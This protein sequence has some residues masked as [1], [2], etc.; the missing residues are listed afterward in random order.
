[1]NRNQQS[2]KI[3]DFVSGYVLP[4][5]SALPPFYTLGI[6]EEQKPKGSCLRCALGL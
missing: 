2:Q 4:F 6:K 5:L 3:A 1:M